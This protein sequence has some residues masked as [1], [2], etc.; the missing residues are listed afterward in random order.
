MKKQLIPLKFAPGYNLDESPYSS[1]SWYQG[2]NM[3]FV[4]GSPQ[5]M[6]GFNELILP[7][8]VN[9]DG[10][11]TTS[12]LPSLF[13]F[14]NSPIQ[15]RGLYSFTLGGAQ[16]Y[17]GNSTGSDTS[18]FVNLQ[19]QSWTFFVQAVSYENNAPFYVYLTALNN[20][21]SAIYI[22]NPV[23]APQNFWGYGTTTPIFLQGGSNLPIV[24]P[25]ERTKWQFGL[26]SL[27][28][29]ISDNNC[30]YA[31]IIYAYENASIQMAMT[32]SIQYQS[33][34][35]QTYGYFYILTIG[36][37]NN[38]VSISNMGTHQNP[39]GYS[40]GPIQVNSG[41]IQMSGGF[42]I[43]GSFLMVYG[44]NGMVRWSSSGAPSTFATDDVAIICL[45]KIVA[46]AQMRGG[47]SGSPSGLFWSLSCLIRVTT[48][49]TGTGSSVTTAFTFDTITSNV[50]ILASQGVVEYNGSFFWIGTNCFYMY[51]GQVQEVSNN[52]TILWF[53]ENLKWECAQN[54]FT[55]VDQLFGEIWWYFPSINSPNNYC[56]M[57]LI[58]NVRENCWYTTN[59]NST[60]DGTPMTLSCG[61]YVPTWGINVLSEASLVVDEGYDAARYPL[62]TENYRFQQS[63]NQSVLTQQYCYG[64]SYFKFQSGQALNSS[65]PPTPL[66]DF[67]ATFFTGSV[68]QDYS[69]GIN[70]WIQTPFFSLF[71]A[72]LLKE[73]S[74]F[75][76]W[77]RITRFEGDFY[78]DGTPQILMTMYGSDYALS[79]PPTTPLTNVNQ[80]QLLSGGQINNPVDFSVQSRYT[81]I[82]FTLD[83][84]QPSLFGSAIRFGTS[85][86]T[87]EVGDKRQGTN[88][89]PQSGE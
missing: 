14:G 8:G 1:S 45:D 87:L 6:M 49:T 13:P 2:S 24:Y 62:Y 5:N 35:E 39:D 51:N 26:M 75:D 28:S 32:N 3:R 72:Q 12:W 37:S 82:I 58:L 59:L 46:S 40:V 76:S 10:I 16:L 73:W 74:P 47:G 11:G 86:L 50:S 52:T 67:S 89:A 60:E 80:L 27:Q 68:I 85:I 34:A 38:Q 43:L 19:P 54:I 56:D 20:D 21:S 55:K 4:K 17:T 30:T 9:T 78:L 36:G 44:D 22:P 23:H 7:I 71:N 63:P 48:T 65:Y 29:D 79:T 64:R 41:N 25:T 61:C 81:S 88:P 18:N 66:T 70:T 84:S 42:L 77:A 31:L 57:A 53:F 83:V 69:T 15:R 33:S